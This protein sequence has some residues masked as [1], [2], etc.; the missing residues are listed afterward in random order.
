M[1]WIDVLS[2]LCTWQCFM[3]EV[4]AVARLLVTKRMFPV[5]ASTTVSVGFKCY[6][7]VG[8]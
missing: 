5:C 6:C 1:P 3:P 8:A 2:A 4:R 7:D